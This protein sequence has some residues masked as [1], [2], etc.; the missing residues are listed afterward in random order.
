MM[1]TN[2]PTMTVKIIPIELLCTVI[3]V[4]IS[5]YAV[6]L[7]SKF[8]VE[9]N[10]AKVVLRDDGVIILLW[11]DMYSRELT[12]TAVELWLIP[13]ETSAVLLISGVIIIL[14]V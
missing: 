6:A 12:N 7:L 1:I 11:V 14:L 5:V 10:V 2:S 4:G 3:D 9:S 8:N 13:G